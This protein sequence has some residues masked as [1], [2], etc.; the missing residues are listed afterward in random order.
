MK[1][2]KFEN[3]FGISKL[4]FN[5][6]VCFDDE[7]IANYL[8]YAPNGT[9]KSSFAKTFSNW[10]NEQ[11]VL[12]RINELEFIGEIE[13]GG[14][15][16][17]Y[18]NKIG[19]T[20][21]YSND[22]NEISDYLNYI[23]QLIMSGLDRNLIQG[24]EEKIEKYEKE[25]LD[26]FNKTDIKFEDYSNIIFSDSNFSTLEI[27]IKFYTG[28]NSSKKVDGLEKIIDIKKI[29]QKA[30][31]VLDEKKVKE[32]LRAY[33]DIIK[34]R[35]NSDFY[36]ELFSETKGQDLLKTLKD[37]AFLSEDSKRG[38]LIDGIE[39]YNLSDLEK[40]F[41]KKLDEILSDPTVIEKSETLQK[42]LGKAALAKDFSD[43]VIQFPEISLNI[44]IGRENIIYSL[45]KNSIDSDYSETINELNKIKLELQKI[46][47]NASKNQNLFNAIVEEYNEIFQPI[48]TI[49][50][51]NTVECLSGNSVPIVVFHHHRDSIGR[52]NLN[53]EKINEYL[54]SGEKSTLK[55]L[56]FMFMYNNIKLN[57][58][59]DEKVLIILDDIV[60]TFDYRNR[61]G[62][63]QYIHT[64]IADKNNELII[65]THNYE[66]YERVYKAMDM[67]RLISLVAYTKKNGNVFIEKNSKIHFNIQNQFKC[68][69]NTKELV[70]R[71]PFFRELSNY[72]G[73]DE[74]SN[75]LNSCLH[76][77]NKTKDISIF[78]IRN[79][80]VENEIISSREITDNTNYLI[81]LVKLASKKT[82]GNYF[83]IYPKIILS[84]ASRIL[85]EKIAINNDLSKLEGI[86]KN[87]TRQ[88]LCLYSKRWIMK[89]QN[90]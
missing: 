69:S 64:L 78:D 1:I 71:I 31:S 60:E 82:S 72:L 57:A 83:N 17:I 59:S 28:I 89:L 23:K 51:E 18:P 36:D 50:V 55:I 41:K 35:L 39:Y 70:S 54:S 49:K 7:N 47:E 45:L 2:I 87:Q 76:Y 10:S 33:Q 9:F 75:L 53:K 63:L 8:I 86:D 22:V 62:F 32:Q 30:Y 34:S 79:Y 40:L 74:N 42:N 68:V 27:L 3:A 26:I 37:S 13:I 80:L 29:K 25:M 19:N 66:F 21:V 15:R 14:N 84:I 44:P 43:K 5:K 48:F 65:L 4:S 88:I 77:K 24:Q 61:A 58:G 81:E 56:D 67:N 85:I 20:I 73:K 11:K 12:D 38:I 46:Y 52:R 16:V 6:Q 90:F